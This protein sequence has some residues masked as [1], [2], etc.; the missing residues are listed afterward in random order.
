MALDRDRTTP[1][2]ARVNLLLAEAK[3]TR[4]TLAQTDRL[5]ARELVAR[6]DDMLKELRGNPYGQ[7]GSISVHLGPAPIKH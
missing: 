2:L 6:R 5:L 4:A 7:S 3:A 1:F